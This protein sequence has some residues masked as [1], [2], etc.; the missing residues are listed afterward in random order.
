MFLMSNDVSVWIIQGK[1]VDVG[2]GQI[3]SRCWSRME[4]REC[5]LSGLLQDPRERAGFWRTY[6]PVQGFQVTILQAGRARA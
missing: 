4:N 1:Y 6:R 2:R 3:L 5:P